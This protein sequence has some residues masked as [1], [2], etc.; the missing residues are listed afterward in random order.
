MSEKRALPAGPRQSSVRQLVRFAHNPIRF[1]E[2]CHAR[3]GDVCTIHF[4]GLPPIVH[5]AT[6]EAA[7]EV[8]SAS[9]TEMS[10]GEAGFALE[11]LVGR[12]ALIR[13]DGARH[14]RERKLM[15]PAVHGE[16]L[17]GF[18]AEM[19]RVT[20]DV[21]S[22]LRPGQTI[23]LQ[24][25]MQEIT[26]QVILRTVFGVEGTHPIKELLVD[27]LRLAMKPEVTVL[28]MLTGGDKLRRSLALRYAP[29][30]EKVARL[31]GPFAH[32]PLGEL[33]QCARELDVVLFDEIR[34]RRAKTE[35]RTDV[36]S[37]LIDAVDDEGRG[38]SDDE[39]R[40][41]MMTLLVGGNETTETSLSWAIA[42]CLQNPNVLARLR[43][44]CE[45]V[46]GS[47]GELDSSRVPELRYVDAV[48]RET[49]RLYPISVGVMRRLK[50]PMTIGGAALPAGVM[51]LPSAYLVHRDPAIWPE[52]LRFDPSRFLERKPRL[53]EWFPFGGGLRTCLG[54]AFS[55]Y[56]MKIVLARIF[57][58]VTLRLDGPIP[59]L[60]Q[61]S[62]LLGP[63]APIPVYVAAVDPPRRNDAERSPVAHAAA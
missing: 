45:S 42:L 62:F 5:L 60:A 30:V 14:K 32:L 28:A 50:Q 16:R 21:L 47:A 34:R 31:G 41:E 2:D 19:C 25:V 36:M 27:F 29:F 38:L 18:G 1:V 44:E 7:R 6:A 23:A 51:V 13:L 61:R 63:A 55:L 40:D 37:V 35:G 48:I 10:A 46:F 59:P 9:D 39:L 22:K 11:L 54:M 57:Q 53:G 12:S 17:V 4:T 20:D 43:A 49:M 26:V 33:A 15:M 8:F 58:R 24:E 3:Y 56:E 52:P